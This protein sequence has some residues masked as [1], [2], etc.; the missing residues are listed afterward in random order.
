MTE[1]DKRYFLST[2]QP[3]DKQPYISNHDIAIGCPIC[4]EGQ[5]TGRKQ[6]CHLYD[7]KGSTLV[8]CFNCDHH[9]NLANFLKSVDLD[10][11]NS[12]T[13]EIKFNR[14]DSLQNELSLTDEVN[15]MNKK[16][17]NNLK[18]FNINDF[19]M[20]KATKSKMAM[21]Y[22]YKRCVS[23]KMFNDF[24][25]IDDVLELDIKGEKKNIRLYTGIV[26][27]L[28]YD[29]SKNLIY[30]FQYR[31][32]KEKQFF[33]Y[34]PI[35]NENYKIYNYFNTT[36]EVYVFE[37]VFDMYSN[38]IHM[39]N[40][41]ALLGSDINEDILNQYK[42][43]IICLDNQN[44]DITAKEKLLKFCDK[45]KNKNIYFHLWDDRINEKDFNSLLCKIHDKYDNSYK[46]IT[47]LIK[48]NIYDTLETEI[49]LKLY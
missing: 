40:K 23:P 2:H 18:V 48:K 37:S 30:G 1:I 46:K 41:I 32:I 16:K 39:K 14:L 47:N 13:N 35:E 4:N 44:V 9:S 21:S 20:V 31:N 15:I 22:L 26:F 10:L 19:N 24:Y 36:N 29:K 6:R 38:D 42:K 45:Y 17:D 27:P 49:R 34:L 28:W 12:Y 3:W 7:Y 11:Y 43:V 5:S 8:H 33:T 25:Y